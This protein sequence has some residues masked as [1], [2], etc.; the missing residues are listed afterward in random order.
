MN[1]LEILATALDYIESNLQEDI[2]TSD[3]ADACFCSKSALEKIFRNVSNIGIREYL[4]KRRMMLAA[5]LLI[6]DN[7]FSLLDISLAVGYSTNESFT[8]A[9]RSVWFCNPSEFRSNHQYMELFPR[10]QPPITEGGNLMS[11]RRNID[12]SELYDLF[13]QRKNCYFVCCD[14]KQLIPINEIS[15]VAGDMAIVESMRRMQNEAGEDDIVFRIGGDEFVMLT[16]S[17]DEA[18]ANSICERITSHNG[19]PIVFENQDIPLSLYAVAL[20]FEAK[21]VRYHDLYTQIHEALNDCK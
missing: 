19:E 5:K 8:R 4:I 3:V 10:L 18:Y 7:E 15:F 13:V 20:K 17:E 6:H 9:F 16:A 2:R 12:I 21:N 1:K 11:T 14:I